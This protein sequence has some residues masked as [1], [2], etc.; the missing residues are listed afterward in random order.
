MSYNITKLKSKISH[1]TKFI[2]CNIIYTQKLASLH[3]KNNLNQDETIPHIKPFN[4][5]TNILVFIINWINNSGKKK[6]QVK[7]FSLELS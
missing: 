1:N 2:I 5:K 7:L 4:S 6:L 3:G